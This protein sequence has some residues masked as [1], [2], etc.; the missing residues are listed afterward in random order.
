M[1]FEVLDKRRVQDITW[2]TNF[3][4]GR[5]PEGANAGPRTYTAQPT[6]SSDCPRRCH[7]ISSQSLSLG[8][9]R[10]LVDL[11]TESTVTVEIAAVMSRC[12]NVRRDAAVSK[13]YNL[14][15][16]RTDGPKDGPNL[17]RTA[18]RGNPPKGR[19]S[20]SIYMRTQVCSHERPGASSSSRGSS[21]SISRGG[22]WLRRF[23]DMQ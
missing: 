8:H 3:S 12:R 20:L 18:L 7:R 1:W 13:V 2:V 15:L 19:L 4:C 11:Y 5:R 9:R 14:H 22:E 16:V 23:A 21:S 10:I 17:E 6:V